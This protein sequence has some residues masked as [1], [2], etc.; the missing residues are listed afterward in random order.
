MTD[1]GQSVPRPRYGQAAE[2]FELPL[3][4]ARRRCAN[5]DTMEWRLM[6]GNVTLKT[7]WLSTGTASIEA[8]QKLLAE[9]DY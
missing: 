9:R 4:I 7:V 8:I 5:L 3:V 1:V 2:E 6:L